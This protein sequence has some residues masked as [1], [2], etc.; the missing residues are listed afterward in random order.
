MNRALIR[1]LNASMLLLA[2]IGM[3]SRCSGPVEP[4]NEPNFVKSTRPASGPSVTAA[5]PPF[6]HAGDVTKQ[7]TITGSG[8]TAGAQAAWERNGAVD[9]KIQVLSTQV[10]NSTQLVATI[11][12]AADAAIDLYDISVTNTDRKKGIGFALFEVTQ[13]IVVDGVTSM[14][15]VNDAGDMT[16]TGGGTIHF[17]PASGLD[18][19][20]PIGKG[21]AVN[22]P[23]TAIVGNAAGPRLWNKVS[24]VWQATLLPTDPSSSGG[25]ASSLSA[26]PSGQVLLIGGLEV[27]QTGKKSTTNEPRLWIRQAVTN[28]WGRIVLPTG[29]TTNLGDVLGVSDNGVAVGW[30]G[31]SSIQA[32]V[33]ESNGSGY[34]LTTLAGNRAMGINRAGTII[35]GASGGVAAYWEHLSG[36]GWSAP[37]TLPGGCGIATAVDD[38]GRIAANSCPEGNHSTPAVFVV[39]YS[40]TTMIR[41]GG[42]GPNLS[43]TVLGMS[44]SGNY[45]VGQLL[46]GSTSTGAYWKIF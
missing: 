46:S 4:P 26:D 41:L 35:V 5:N 33:W 9:P 12:I 11:T 13:A 1:R 23:G 24:G 27:V 18:L 45:V 44:P 21:W 34:S 8:F 31:G 14:Q 10:V 22:Q 42:Q 15:G 29:P 32:V 20:D 19:V 3:V 7:V 43:G 28:D 36:G 25:R 30:I 2:G 39:P 40:T 16:G 37:I 17:N 6:G 38:L